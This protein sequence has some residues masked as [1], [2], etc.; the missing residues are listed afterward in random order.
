[1]GGLSG[2]AFFAVSI[3]IPAAVLHNVAEDNGKTVS[4]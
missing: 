2:N 3:V 1:L 4:V